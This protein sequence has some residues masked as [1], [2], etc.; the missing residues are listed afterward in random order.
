MFLILILIL[1][2]QNR[3]YTMS[4]SLPNEY[5]QETLRYTIFHSNDTFFNQNSHLIKCVSQP[6]AQLHAAGE[7]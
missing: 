4:L 2:R 3:E 5:C 1:N 6:E 7:N